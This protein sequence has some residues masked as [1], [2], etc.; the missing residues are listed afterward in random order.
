MTYRG[1]VQ[2]GMIVLD[3]PVRLPEGSWVEVASVPDEPGTSESPAPSIADRYAGMIGIVDGLPSDLS[4]EHD[5]Y[6]HGV[7]RRGG[8]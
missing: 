3:P 8:E 6:I 7:P 4:A 2:N 1:R 5:H